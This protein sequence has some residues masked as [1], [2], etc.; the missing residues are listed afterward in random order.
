MPIVS[1]DCPNGPRNITKNKN[2]GFLI[3]DKNKNSFAEHLIL[4]IENDNLR[5]TLS[6]NA[7]LNVQ[8]FSKSN[9]I[10]KWKQLL[11]SLQSI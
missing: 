1:Y 5:V 3:E 9:V 10:D 2:D 7:R 11:K 6:Q 4:L 8:R